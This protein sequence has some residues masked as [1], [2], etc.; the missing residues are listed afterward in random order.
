MDGCGRHTEY[1]R[2]VKGRPNGSIAGVDEL[3]QQIRLLLRLQVG[4]A[5]PIVVQQ[6]LT[7]THRVSCRRYGWDLNGQR[8]AQIC[9]EMELT[10]TQFRLLK[11]RAKARFG[12]L[13][14]R[15]LCPPLRRKEPA[16]RILIETVLAG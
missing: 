2:R 14:K 10:E 5:A 6:R 7:L 9:F 3:E 4:M 16:H 15:R 1:Y 8:S 12:M 13:G 11:S